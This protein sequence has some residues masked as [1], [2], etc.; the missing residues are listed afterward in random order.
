MSEV[1]FLPVEDSLCGGFSGVCGLLQ[2]RNKKELDFMH[3]CKHFLWL[4][5][6]TKFAICS[7]SIYE[8]SFRGRSTKKLN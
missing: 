4:E 7:L 5:F 6:T 8:H 3:R 1:F 2:K